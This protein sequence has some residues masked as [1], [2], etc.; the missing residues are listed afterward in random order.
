M[1]WDYARLYWTA[2]GG[3]VSFT[4]QDDWIQLPN[5]LYMDVLADLGAMEWEL[6][7]VTSEMNVQGSSGVYSG[8][9]HTTSTQSMRFKRPWKE[10][11]REA[12]V[13][14]VASWI[15]K[16]ANKSGVNSAMAQEVVECG[17]EEGRQRQSLAQELGAKT[18]VFGNQG[19]SAVKGKTAQ[20]ILE[21]MKKRNRTG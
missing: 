13:A 5:Q 19:P 14:R 8:S 9:M 1:A 20:E 15:T 10:G 17:I 2:D 21:G 12:H 7:G 6:V 3:S 4:C 18:M 11:S 16:A